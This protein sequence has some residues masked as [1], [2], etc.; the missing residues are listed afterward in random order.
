VFAVRINRIYGAF[1]AALTG[2]G[3]ALALAACGH[4]AEVRAGQRFG[5]AEMEYRLRP[6]HIVAAS[7][8]RL[9]ISVH[10][11]GRLSHNLVIVRATPTTTVLSTASG[12]AT[13]TTTVAARTP[14]LHPGQSTTLAV[15]L[16]PGRYGIAS[17][18][19]SD[20]SLGEQGTL[21]VVSK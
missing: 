10:N 15:T 7:G 6:S 20:Q 19:D 14:D 8:Q 21:T 11:Y 13:E 5:I 2:V 12:T 17:T 1:I 9:R 18:L 16:A 4:T 3:T